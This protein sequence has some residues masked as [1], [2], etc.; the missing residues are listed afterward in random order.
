M[1]Q[2]VLE[3]R[4]LSCW[5]VIDDIKVVRA[6][7]ADNRLTKDQM[8]NVLLGLEELYELKFQQVYHTFEEYQTFG[9]GDDYAS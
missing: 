7:I 5:N 8:E 3:Q 1:R 9:E 4:I 2:F 6:A